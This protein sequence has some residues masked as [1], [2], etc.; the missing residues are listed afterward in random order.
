MRYAGTIALTILLACQSAIVRAG[1]EKPEIEAAKIAAAFR[2]HCVQTYFYYRTD[3]GDTPSVGEV[4]ADIANRR[5]TPYGGYWWDDKTILVGDPGVGDRFIRSVEIAVPGSE[6]RYPA[7]VAG[8]FQK[9]QALLLEV[10]PNDLGEFPQAHPVR[11]DNSPLP[12]ANAVV[13]YHWDNGEW[14]LTVGGPIAADSFNDAGAQTAEVGDEGGIVVTAEGKAIGAVFGKEIAMSAGDEFWRGRGLTKARVIGAAEYR[15]LQHALAAR[16]ANSVLETRLHLRANIDEDEFF[17]SVT[18]G[19][20]GIDDSTHEI[21]LPGLLANKRHL[22]VPASLSAATI[23]RIESIEIV[24]PDGREVE[25]D[26]VGACRDYLAIIIAAREDLDDSD[27]PAGFSFLDPLIVPEEAFLPGEEYLALPDK[28]LFLRWHIDYQLGRRRER[29]DYDRWLGTFRGFRGDPVVA[30]IT[31][32][33]EGGLAF[34]LE[35]KLLAVAMAPRIPTSENS[36]QV[37]RDAGFRPLGHI[38]EV[39]SRQ[40]SIDP[41]LLPTDAE[42]GKR[43][44]AIGVEWQGLDANSARLFGAEKATRGGDIG[45]LVSHVYP[46]SIADKIGLKEQDIL[47]RI[48]VRGRSEPI[49]LLPAD[50][51]MAGFSLLDLEDVSVESVQRFMSEL[52][53]PWPSRENNLT[54]LLTS[55]GVDRQIRLEYLHEGELRH[56]EFTTAFAEPDYRTAPKYKVDSLG[57]TVKPITYEAA[58]YFRRPDRAGVIVSKVEDGSRGAVA[59][60]YPYLLITRVDGDKVDD[61]ASFKTM[62]DAFEKGIRREI[63]LAVEGFG[64]TRLVKIEK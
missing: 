26:F 4:A 17:S 29:S 2:K 20:D 62:V 5:S 58:A 25:A 24:L 8:R 59:G 61:F 9:L 36:D 19:D 3:D 40:A 32:E 47:L 52:P 13:A 15:D 10:Q 16:L 51:H 37:Y 18:S 14:R 46:G 55:I 23:A 7:R 64:K 48:Q 56:A 12:D 41:T 45:L 44:I 57:M 30:T 11:F 42:N 50:G 6:E 1:D 54:T 28:G 33:R 31:N 49:E 53:P 27:V 38:H 63:E 21:K 60:L 39:L 34:D 22:F 35:G 43:L